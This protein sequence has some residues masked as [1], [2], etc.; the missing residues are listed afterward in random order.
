MKWPSEEEQE[1]DDVIGVDL[2]ITNIAAT[3]D[4]ETYAGAALNA[5]RKQREKNA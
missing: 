3:D 5:L 2:G 1:F 4:G